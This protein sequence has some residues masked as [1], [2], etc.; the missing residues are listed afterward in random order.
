MY[1]KLVTRLFIEVLFL[2]IF[3]VFHAT[4]SQ[5]QLQYN[6]E[7]I[8]TDNGLPTNA[9]KGLQFDEKTRFLW[10]ATESGIVRYNGHGF[11]NF[12]DN[13]ANAALNGR[14][15]FF[16]KAI[17]GRL[18]GK[19]ID[20]R[21]FIIKENKAII[22]TAISQ[23]AFQ[24]DYLTYKY[25]IPPKKYASK[26]NEI[27]LSD[28]MFKGDIYT[29]YDYLLYKFENDFKPIE[30]IKNEKFPFILNERLYFLHSEGL[31]SD[32]QV[33]ENQLIKFINTDLF[34]SIL[35][36]KKKSN[37]QIHIFQNHPSEPVY[38]TFGQKLYTIKQ[39]DNQLRFDLITD[40]LPEI[41]FIKYIQVDRETNTIYIGTD[42]R[43]LIIARPKYF[44]RILPVNQVSGVSSSTYAQLL[45]KNGNI[46]IN[47]GQFFGNNN[48]GS[49][50]IFYK[51]SNT[52][53]YLTRDSVLY[54]TNMDGIVAFDLKTDKIQS[55]NNNISANRNSFFEIE[56]KLYS[57][58]ESGIAVKEQFNQWFY[59]LKFKKVPLN[60]IVYDI[61]KINP[62]ELLI[63]TTD[64]LY[65]YNLERNTFNLFF[66]DR[67]KANFRTIFALDNYFLIGTYGSGVYM[68][69]NDTIKQLPF[70]QNKFLS[71][72]HCFLQDE[73]K[74]VWASTNK[75]LFMSLQSS[76]IDFWVKGPGN[77]KFTYFGKSDGIDQLEFNGGCTP[78]AIKLPDGRFSFPGIDGLVQFDP[79]EISII[80]IQP[81]IYIDKLIIDGN[82]IGSDFLNKELNSKTKSIEI[83]LGISGML[84]EENIML[85]YKLDGELWTRTN[86]KNSNLNFSNLSYGSHV[87]SIRIRNT[88]DDKWQI[89]QFPF[90]IKYPWTLNPFMYLV[91]LTIAICIVLLYIRFKTLIY[92]RRQKQLEIEVNSKT[93]S[94]NK[95]NE[96]LTKRNQ[97][98]DH[99]IAIMNHD[100]LTPLKY[101]H[102]TA[103]NISESKNPNQVKSSIKQIA[104]TSKEL[105]YLTSNMLNWV[106]FDNIERLPQKQVF[107]LCILVN[108]LIEFVHP[109]VQNK[110]IIILNVV[111]PESFINNWPDSLRVLL[112]NFIINAIN[113]THAGT[114]KIG[115][116]PI[117]GGY[118][119]FIE[120]TGIGMS[121]SMV[122]FLLKGN[123]EDLVEI[124]PKFKSGNGIGYQI[125]RNI[126]KLMNA[127]LD[128]ESI[129]NKGTTINI[130][131]R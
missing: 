92:Q 93:E 35:I 21:V 52:S 4:I 95:L 116:K 103:K 67:N 2:G 104:D 117:E 61:K 42:N 110:K 79:N 106:K 20:G 63:A 82:N 1:T 9:I 57:F 56:N 128:I 100:I 25:K 119:L 120:D 90:S 28:F 98:K 89:F 8:N 88:I 40:Q 113:A 7:R 129:E 101:M 18:F 10:V 123:Y 105:E 30:K 58:N 68:Y 23:M 36:K 118:L 14:I 64:G 31:I 19:L 16:V 27:E 48:T 15:N 34:K 71:Y 3:I 87:I 78:C 55:V 59:I 39:Y 29:S 62:F 97:A 94:L 127:H 65:K 102:I 37:Y 111:P 81:K 96:Y 91:Y 108:D 74:R 86:V 80:K 26:R 47:T 11:Q 53:T 84:T 72:T 54:Y 77:I 32:A 130:V 44:N 49:K 115:Y 83:Q 12:G 75:G 122:E 126:V 41:D 66:R 46:Q 13:D 131:F 43:G 33:K 107:D 22:D 60:F 109:F 17:D 45:L 69:K 99:V 114:I 112:Y 76:L 6:F 50:N 121:S 70:D 5:A 125:I 124:H 85:E 51:P 38:L 73:Q 24:E